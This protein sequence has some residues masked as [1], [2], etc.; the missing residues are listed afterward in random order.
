M[1]NLVNYPEKEP[2]VR[3]MRSQLMKKLILNNST[4]EWL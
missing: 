3:L 4:E 2:F 1:N